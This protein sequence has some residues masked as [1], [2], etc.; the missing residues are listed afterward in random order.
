V[1]VSTAELFPFLSPSHADLDDDLPDDESSTV[2]LNLAGRA[3]PRQWRA[4]H[5]YESHM[6]RHATACEAGR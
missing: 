5:E 4:L 1:N 2:K 3:T 6:R